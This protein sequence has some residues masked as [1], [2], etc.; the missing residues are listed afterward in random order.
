MTKDFF[1]TV[2][3]AA[4][5]T[6]I[7]EWLI[8]VTALLYV[9][10]AAIENVWC[11][12]FG[13]LSSLFSIYLCYSGRLFL[14]SGLN[15]F[16]VV[17]GIYGWYQ[18][19][20]GSD[21]KTELPLISYSFKKNLLLV[22]IGAIIWIPFGFAAHKFSTQAMPYLDA[23]ITA[24][25]IVATWMTAKKIIENW[26]YWIVIDALAILLYT[27]RGFYLIGL[28]YIIY[29]LLAVAGYISWRKKLIR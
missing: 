14:E 10:L 6:S 7:T 22:L 3:G 17:I 1:D 25:S 19:L 2:V 16:Y 13:I 23:F 4:K 26:L 28:L 20:Y 11:W 15:V 12:L 8:F 29:T 21:K 9:L 5:E 27:Y 24:F 18:W